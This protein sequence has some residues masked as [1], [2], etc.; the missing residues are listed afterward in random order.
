MT[1]FPCFKSLVESFE[2]EL[3]SDFQAS[4]FPETMLILE[5]IQLGDKDAEKFLK[6]VPCFQ[7]LLCFLTSPF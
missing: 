4:T 2:M 7:Y 5:L 1:A 6:R 3:R